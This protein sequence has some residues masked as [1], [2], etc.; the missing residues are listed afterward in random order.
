MDNNGWNGWEK[1]LFEGCVVCRIFHIQL[2]RY[3]ERR[4]RVKELESEG[5]MA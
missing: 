2:A 1:V 4:P 3:G 5:E